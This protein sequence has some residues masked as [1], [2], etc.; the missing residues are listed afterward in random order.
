MTDD[1]IVCSR[2]VLAKAIQ[3][4]IVPIVAER[5]Q[6]GTMCQQAI[7]LA[8]DRSDVLKVIH[9]QNVDLRAALMRLLDST[10]HAKHNCGDSVEDCPVAFARSVLRGPVRQ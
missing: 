6:M 4:A 3:D 2:A 10:E 5:N 1:I 7:N 9:D 8:R